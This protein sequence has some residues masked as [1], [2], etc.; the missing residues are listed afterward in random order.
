MYRKPVILLIS[1][2]PALCFTA[3]SSAVDT[4]PDPSTAA[5]KAVLQSLHN[6]D[7]RRIMGRLNTLAYEREFTELEIYR[8]RQENLEALAT[9][10]AD[11][12]KIAGQLPELFPDK[13]MSEEDQITF[14][15]MAN[16]LQNETLHLL[17]TSATSSYSE[18]QTGYQK[19]GK[20]CMACHNLFR[21]W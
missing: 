14:R 1:L 8:I 12:V 5:G 18:R 9:A 11:L 19:L 10:A 15:A 13:Q 7:I 16:Q 6:E 20:T 21:D 4:E 17:D 3:I 2:V